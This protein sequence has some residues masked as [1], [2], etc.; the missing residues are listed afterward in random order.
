MFR[1]I[2]TFTSRSKSFWSLSN[3]LQTF[4]LLV[5]A[6][7][8]VA[9]P[10]S[11]SKYF[12]NKLLRVEIR[13]NSNI[14]P[15]FLRVQDINI[16][17]EIFIDETYKAV[18]SKLPSSEE[19]LVVDLGAHI[20][21]ASIF[22]AVSLNSADIHAYEPTTDSFRILKMNSDNFKNIQPH[23]LAVAPID[24]PVTFY[25]RSDY[26][27]A[28]SAIENKELNTSKQECSA[29][30]LDSIINM[31][32]KEISLLK[33]DIEDFEIPVF[34]ASEKRRE[35]ETIIGEFRV[36]PLNDIAELCDLFSSTHELEIVNYGRRIRFFNAYKKSSS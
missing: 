26:Q 7:I 16:F 14:F 2:K 12:R 25:I 4:C 28:N 30:S 36:T 15:L 10:L 5:I 17:S 13:Y 18:L 20:G 11:I 21:M 22:F 33:F 31:H 6:F 32:D 34:R 23:N 3:N 8:I 24:G 27:S 19:L 29:L 1:K 35:L 9:C